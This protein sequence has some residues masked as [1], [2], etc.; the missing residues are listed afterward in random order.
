MSKP[1]YE[2]P[3]TDPDAPPFGVPGAA[4]ALPPQHGELPPQ[5]P[6]PPVAPAVA[7]DYSQLPP[8]PAPAAVGPAVVPPALPSP[9]P[10]ASAPRPRRRHPCRRWPRRFRRARRVDSARASCPAGSAC[11][12]PDPRTRRRRWP[13]R[14]TTGRRRSPDSRRPRR[15]SPLLAPPA[16]VDPLAAP[17]T[18]AEPEALPAPGV[19]APSV[20]EPIIFVDDEKA[21]ATRAN[22]DPD[23]LAALQEVLLS[24]ASD[25][26]V[27]SGGSPLLRIDGGLRPVTGDKVWDREKVESA[28]HS[29]LS[30]EQRERFEEVLELDFAF[31]LSANARFRVNFYQQRG[32]I[33][34]AFR[35]IPTGIKSL[36]AARCSGCRSASS[37]SCP[38]V[39]CWSPARP[40]PASRRRWPRSSTW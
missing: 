7:P 39:W 16:A 19:A 40:V 36:D 26:H 21:K 23:L 3:V 2:I 13:P 18:A 10:V 37:R 1:V 9:A 28:L 6:A 8:P 12:A 14:S 33:G 17:P 27:S 15:S 22:A 30:A 38:V 29:I 5:P 4:G 31:T 24:G 32:A 34:G 25:L 11:A 20:P 35:L